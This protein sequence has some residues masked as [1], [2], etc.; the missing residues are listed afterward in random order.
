MWG[1]GTCQ[2]AWGLDDTHPRTGGAPQARMQQATA[3]MLADM[4]SL[5]A[6]LQSGL[7]M[8]STSTDHTAP[9][10]TITFPAAGATVPVGLAADGHRHRL[11]RRRAWSPRSRCRSTAAP[12][13]RGPRAPPSWSFVFIPTA[14]GPL[15]IRSRAIDDSVNTETPGP[16]VTVTGGPRAF[17][18]SI[19]HSSI[20][21][22]RPSIAD[23]GPLE[24]GVK[25][26]TVED[27]FVTGVRFYK[28]AGNTGTHV[29]HLWSA[30]AAPR[31]PRSPSPARP[32]SGWQQALFPN[33][34]AVATN[35]T[36]I[37]SYFAPNGHYAGDVGYF[38]NAYDVWPL[39]ALS[40]A[41]DGPNGVFRYGSTGFPDTSFNAT[42]Y[43][44]DVVFDIDDHRAPTVVD[45]NPAPGLDGVASTPRISVR[46]SE[47]MTGSSI[48][49]DL[50]GP[51]RRPASPAPSPT[52][53]PP[54]GPPSRPR[55]RSTR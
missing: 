6:T 39:R 40:V 8:P 44:V 18:A 5:P 35:T 46:F 15:T 3:N 2:W 28:G 36:Y 30:T 49:I 31:S 7:V 55:P 20:T 45:R 21:P 54:G 34:V 42:N 51:R 10:S 23:N 50:I 25:F 1:T 29:G 48:D 53:A 24:L 37:V 47:A 14:L 19:W 11:R 26:R 43:W 52:T 16:G 17:P 33:P 41:E 12:P 27:G 13:G 22:T 38:N 32:P 9:V 4:G